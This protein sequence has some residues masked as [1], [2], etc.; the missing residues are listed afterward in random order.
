MKKINQ[1]IA[2]CVLM[3]GFAACSDSGTSANTTTT[4]SDTSTSTTSNTAATDNGTGNPAETS[5][6]T[7][8]SAQDSTFV[9]KAAMGGMME[10]E[11]GNTAQQNAAH[12][13]VKAYATMMVNDHS[14]AN[15][16][17]TALVGGRGI[18][19]PTSMPTDMQNHLEEMRKMKGKQFDNH[20]M[21]MMVN[22]HQKNNC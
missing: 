18:T 11:A 12:D 20:Y 1:S 5:P 19:I 16:E 22:D 6:R 21:S 7:P 17:L 14:K 8:L 10:V 2:G 9:M 3:I 4:T 15:S 13:R